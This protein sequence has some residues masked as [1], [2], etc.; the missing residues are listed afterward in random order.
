VRAPGSLWIAAVAALA[1]TGTT[2]A[3]ANPSPP[4]PEKLLLAQ[5]EPAPD[6]YV[7]PGHSRPD[8]TTVPQRTSLHPWVVALEANL[9]L[10]LSTIS[11]ALPPVGWGA[12]VTITR[13]IA[14][15]GHM[16]FGFG[17]QFGYQRIEH[18]KVT[19]GLDADGNN[20]TLN[21]G[22]QFQ[23]NTTFAALLVLDGI[24]GRVRPFFDAGAGLSVAQYYDPTTVAERQTINDTDVIGL[25]T[26]AAGVAVEITRGIE[27]GVAGHFDFLIS[28]R[29]EPPAETTTPAYS[30]FS[31][32]IFSVRLQLGFRF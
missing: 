31:P 12:G 6:D 10:K 8:P 9:V 30:V 5:A 3:R 24:F 2:T 29:K 13:A 18:L 19:H 27:I 4:S 26:L 32:G 22:E 11:P 1:A 20:Q 23:A 16:R 14:N 7:P 25:I 21:F 17:G 28:S 15:F